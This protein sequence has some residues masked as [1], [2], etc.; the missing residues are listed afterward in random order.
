VWQR[1]RNWELASTFH[2]YNQVNLY[3]IERVGIHH[4]C[5]ALTAINASKNST[6]RAGVVA[7]MYLNLAL[8]LKMFSRRIP[9]CIISGLL[10]KSREMCV[11]ASVG[12][13]LEWILSQEGTKY[14]LSS[15]SNLKVDLES[16][17]TSKCS[18]INPVSLLIHNYRNKQLQAV[19]TTLI[20]PN[21]ENNL[22]TVTE[23]LDSVS[24]SNDRQG[25]LTSD[26]DDPIVDWWL[27]MFRC[28]Y[29]WYSNNIEEANNMYPEIDHLPQL[30]QECEDPAYVGLLA[31]N[32]T[33]R[34]VI[35]QDYESAVNMC[36][37]SSEIIQD[38][39][40]YYMQK[41]DRKDVASLN[42]VVLA[43]DWLLQAR[44]Q[45]WQN[46][47]DSNMDSSKERCSEDIDLNNQINST[48]RGQVD[49]QGF[50]RDL[51]SL[52]MLVELAPWLQDRLN[53]YT[54]VHRLAAL[55]PPARTQ[56]LLEQTTTKLAGRQSVV[57]IGGRGEET[58]Y[59]AEWE[60]AISQL[61]ACQYL[62]IQLL[63]TPGER[64][65]MLTEAARLLDKLG[66]KRRGEQVSTL[67]KQLTT[68]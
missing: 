6:S 25:S 5:T 30:Y 54:G 32:I 63:A 39:V 56:Q 12:P 20:F 10:N 13:E 57:C 62:P 47:K 51:H 67:L 16:G 27:A 1:E 66:D 37:H 28:T 2:Q 29:L 41:K 48:A 40:R 9:S 21:Q 11:S 59:L 3:G 46:F 15:Q 31:C 36:H 7:E 38:A 49:L 14:L 34:S 61:L 19:L 50:Q 26:R 42:I 44:T 17:M 43:L 45:I 8:V 4:L 24:R 33:L 22:N 65:G 52:R 68:H 58:G 64:I 60:H 53:M 55:A 18:S 23:I 35:Q